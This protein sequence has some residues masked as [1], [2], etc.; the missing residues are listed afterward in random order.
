MFILELG[1]GVI[2]HTAGSLV[3][4]PVKKCLFSPQINGEKN[5]ATE[6]IGELWVS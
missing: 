3:S 6:F 4:S 1:I 2:D 5:F